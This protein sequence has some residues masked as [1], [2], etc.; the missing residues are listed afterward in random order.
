MSATKSQT[1]GRMDTRDPRWHLA[2]DTIS[3]KEGGHQSGTWLQ[4]KVKQL[5]CR[6]RLFYHFRKRLDRSESSKLFA[7]SGRGCCMYE[8][9]QRKPVKLI[10]K[11]EQARHRL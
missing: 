7:L 11:P 2:R 6:L 8:L 9:A 1:P 3:W 10:D 4:A 5:T